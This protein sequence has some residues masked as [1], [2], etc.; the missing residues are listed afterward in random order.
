MPK[1]KKKVIKKKESLFDEDEIYCKKCGGC[2]YI[3]CD[4]I[5]DFLKYHVK[6]KTD[7][8]QEATFISEIISYIEN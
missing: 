8:S 7:C 6:G 3:G 4:G 2:G 1:T 5:R